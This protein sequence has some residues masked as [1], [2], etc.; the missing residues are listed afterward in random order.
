MLRFDQRLL[1]KLANLAEGYYRK[2]VEIE[3]SGAGE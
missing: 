1:D 3:S 2:M